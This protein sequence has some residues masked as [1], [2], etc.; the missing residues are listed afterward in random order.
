MLSCL[1]QRPHQRDDRRRWLDRLAAS[2]DWRS[3]QLLRKGARPNEG[4]LKDRSGDFISHDRRA[5]TLAHYLCT[6]QWAPRATT[7]ME[8]SQLYPALPVNTADIS[9]TEL[10]R[11]LK[12]FKL[13]KSTGP[14][15]IPVEF[16]LA[17]VN[18]PSCGR[19]WLLE[20]CNTVWRRRVVPQDWHL[21][22]VAMIFKKDDPS[23]CSN[24]RP[25]CLLNSAYKIFAM[26]IL[27]RLLDAGADERLWTTQFGFRRKRSTE[28]ALHCARRAIEAAQGLKHG[29][30]HLLALDWAK[31]FDSI[32]PASLLTSLR[33]FGLPEYVLD[34][35][36]SIYSDRKFFVQDCGVQSSQKAQHSGICQGCPLSPFLFGIIMTTLMTDAYKLLSPEALQAHEQGDLYDLL[37]AD[38]TLVLGCTACHVEELAVA[39]SQAGSNYGLILHWRKIQA[40]SIC[41]NTQLRRPDGSVIEDKGNMLYLGGLLTSVSGSQSEL[42]RGLGLAGAAFKALR[43]LWNHSSVSKEAKLKYFQCF[44]LSALTYGLSTL[45]FT[46]AQKRRMDGF[47]ARCLRRILRIPAAFISRISNRSVFEQA[48]AAPLSQLLLDQPFRLFGRVLRADIG[49][50]LRKNTLTERNDNFFNSYVRRRG[51]PQMNWVD[52]I[53]KSGATKYG[54]TEDFL[55]NAKTF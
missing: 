25:I 5:D 30:V 18:N 32:S 17:V 49:D 40:L 15:N 51:R 2:G 39:I 19:E 33:R 11:A 22:R 20:F 26:V 29:C 8:D 45:A 28:Q 9:L 3:L 34:I 16:W 41:A 55:Q 1:C 12:K 54:C 27:H 44:V 35:I 13:A 21:Q 50:P 31:A 7:P 43:R 46:Q 38:D 36:S 47:H 52:F 24:Y 6:V 42:S 14:D 37:Y 53:F 23:E 4:R 10:G 48:Q